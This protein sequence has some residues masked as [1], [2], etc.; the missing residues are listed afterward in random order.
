M[1]SHFIQTVVLQ[2]Y[3]IYI[4]LVPDIYQENKNQ[5]LLFVTQFA[6]TRQNDAFLEI[7]IFVSVISINLKVFF[8][9]NTN[10]VLQILFELQ[11]Y[12]IAREIS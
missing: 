10:T 9:I 2:M 4:I 8:C 5:Q 11:G 3:I 7:Q 6:K 12:K 1:D